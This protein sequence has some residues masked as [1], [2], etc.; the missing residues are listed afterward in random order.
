MTVDVIGRLG[1]RDAGLMGRRRTRTLG[2]LSTY[3]GRF[4]QLEMILYSSSEKKFHF[5]VSRE[6]TRCPAC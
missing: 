2:E 6:A 5:S 3:A 4:W 1:R